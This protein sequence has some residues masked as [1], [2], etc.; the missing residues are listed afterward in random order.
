MC[1]RNVKDAT[2]LDHEGRGT[3]PSISEQKGKR[4]IPA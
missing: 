2:V 3:E 1:T 4:V